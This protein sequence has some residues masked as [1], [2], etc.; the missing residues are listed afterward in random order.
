MGFDGLF[1]IKPEGIR[2][3][4]SGIGNL[5]TESVSDCHRVS[6]EILGVPWE[7]WDCLGRHR[8]E[9]AVDLRLRRQPDHSR[10]DAGC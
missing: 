3:I 5:G 4:Q 9:S 8:Q 7:K 6:A 1:V 10:D 2:Y